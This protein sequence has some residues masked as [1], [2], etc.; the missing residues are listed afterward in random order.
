METGW[1]SWDHVRRLIHSS[2]CQR[3]SVDQPVQGFSGFWG[4]NSCNA[5]PACGSTA[6]T[7]TLGFTSQRVVTANNLF[8]VQVSVNFARI[9]KVRLVIK[10]TGHDYLG[11]STGWGSLALNMHNM[12]QIEFLKSYSGASNYTGS[13]FKLG[14]GVMFKEIY[15][16]AKAQNVD[17]VA[18][19]GPVS[20]NS[21]CIHY[22]R[23][24]LTCCKDSWYS[25]R[26]YP[27]RGPQPLKRH[28]W[29]W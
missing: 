2:L 20:L 27:R 13:A 9:N 6:A 15:A 5:K 28:L 10:N 29:T 1:R 22:Q 23:A 17:I 21:N 12:R 18:G 7:C 8:D 4:N 19:E 26:V 14:A 11:R 16:A 3:S 24:L 25:R